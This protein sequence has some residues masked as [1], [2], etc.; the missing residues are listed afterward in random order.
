MAKA[1]VV[2]SKDACTIIFTG[3]KTNPEPTTGIIKFP[4][5]IIEVSRTTDGSYWAHLSITKPEKDFRSAIIDSRIDYNFNSKLNIISI[6][7]EANVE[8]IALRIKKLIL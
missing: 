5:G 4:G 8:H 7:N 6:P 1:K 3:E 2:H